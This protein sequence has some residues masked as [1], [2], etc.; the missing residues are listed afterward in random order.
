MKLLV[1]SDEGVSP[2]SLKQ[3]M[4]ALK[5]H[6]TLRVDRTSLLKHIEHASLLIFPG[7]RDV[8]YH[9]ALKGKTNAAIRAFVEEGGN[10]LGLCAGGYYGAHSIEFEKG[11]PLEVT[12][13]RELA[14][15]PGYAIGPAYGNGMFDYQSES[16]SRIAQLIYNGREIGVYYNG[17]C[18]YPD[19]E[20]TPGTRVLAHYADLP[21]RPAAIIE[22]TVGKGK[23]ILSGVHPEYDDTM[24]SNG[25]IK[26]YCGMLFP[27]LLKRLLYT[28][29]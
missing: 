26:N 7:G 25:R 18:Y 1:Y 17:G 5:G 2:R 23:A 10:Y 19:A 27:D 8:P 28:K 14:F 6:E 12:G 11:Y 3:L 15:F 13:T 22:C 21:N 9:E 24:P 29:N 16:G 4:R 20:T